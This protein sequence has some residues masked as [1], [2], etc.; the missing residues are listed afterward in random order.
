LKDR[1]EMGRPSE[2]TYRPYL[3]RAQKLARRV[4]HAV[5]NL[6]E[7]RDCWL[8]PQCGPG[9]AIYVARVQAYELA[10]RF[11]FA[12][13]SAPQQI[14]FRLIGRIGIRHGEAPPW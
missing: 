3:D 7:P 12:G 6:Q 4:L 13:G 14:V 11:P 9:H 8:T 1:Q 5:I 10:K 2:L